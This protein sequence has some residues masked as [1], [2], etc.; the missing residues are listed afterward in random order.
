IEGR[1]ECAYHGLQ[2]DSTGQCVDIPSQPGRPIPKQARLQHMPVVEQD[3]M[4]WLWPGDPAECEG[5]EPPRLHEA[6]DP[7]LDGQPFPNVIDSP[8][9]Y[10]LLIENLLDISHFYPLHDGNI[11]DRANSEI[12]VTLQE[13]EKDGFKYVKTIR[14]TTD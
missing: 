1:L 12:P 10:M 9:N 3:T 6:V 8:A 5:I 13:G 4:V 14:E 11:G 7:N 2:Y